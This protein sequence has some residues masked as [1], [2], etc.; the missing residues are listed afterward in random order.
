MRQNQIDNLIN[1]C[2]NFHATMDCNP[3]DVDAS[4]ILEKWNKY[5]G[6]KVQK[7]DQIDVDK[8]KKELSLKFVV[9]RTK[10]DVKIYKALVEWSEKWGIEE[11]NQVKEILNFILIV[12]TKGFR[13]KHYLNEQNLFWDLD[14]LVSVFN[15]HFGSTGNINTEKYD[16]LHVILKEEVSSWLEMKL[17][18]RQYKIMLLDIAD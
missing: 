14:E 13:Y 16:H 10:T 1:F 18:N 7:Y 17:V 15:Q 2:F 11:Y 12:N 5:I 4:Y 6:I 9:G 8:L 3:L